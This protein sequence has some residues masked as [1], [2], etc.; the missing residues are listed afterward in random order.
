MEIS[1]NTFS[2][3]IRKYENEI[4]AEETEEIQDETSATVKEFAEQQ[5]AQSQ[6]ALNPSGG[7][8]VKT[9]GE[10]TTISI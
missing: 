1:N 2:A 5:V 7:C 9:D 10:I 6:T 8:F 3:A 4:K